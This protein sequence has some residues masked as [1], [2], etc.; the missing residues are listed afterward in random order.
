LK[1]SNLFPAADVILLFNRARNTSKAVSTRWIWGRRYNVTKRNQMILRHRQFSGCSC[2]PRAAE[3]APARK[4]SSEMKVTIR[5]WESSHQGA[6]PHDPPSAPT[7][8]G[9][10]CSRARANKLGRLG[11]VTTEPSRS[12][13]KA[14]HSVPSTIGSP[15]AMEISGYGK[16][17]VHRQPR[18]PDG[19]VTKYKIP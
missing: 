12:I 1:S 6:H 14:G 3:A 19:A 5:E 18:P 10:L 9:A 4:R 8:T 7:P 2:T 16:F 15:I 13:A 11:P 17:R